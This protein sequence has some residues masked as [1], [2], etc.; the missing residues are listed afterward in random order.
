MYVSL[1]TMVIRPIVYVYTALPIVTCEKF[2]SCLH[3]TNINKISHRKKS[4]GNFLHL[5]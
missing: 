2:Y 3:V 5:N 1:A 4:M